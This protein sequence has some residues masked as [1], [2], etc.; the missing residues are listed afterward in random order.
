MNPEA[1][2]YIQKLLS[3]GVELK[4][5]WIDLVD[6]ENFR[7]FED[8][9]HQFLFTDIEQTTEPD[10][11]LLE[12]LEKPQCS[13]TKPIT[14]QIDEIIDVSISDK[15][16]LQNI[17]SKFPTL[18]VLINC[19]G[20][21]IAGVIHDQ[22]QNLDLDADPGVKILIKPG[23]SLL[24][25]VLMIYNDN[26]VI[27]GGNSP[28]L[29][30]QRDQAI[31][32]DSKISGF[33]NIEELFSVIPEINFGIHPNYEFQDFTAKKNS[34]NSKIILHAPFQTIEHQESKEEKEEILQ[35]IPKSKEEI[36][37]SIQKLKIEKEEIFQPI[38]KPKTESSS[39]PTIISESTS[40]MPSF[41][42]IKQSKNSKANTKEMLN[43][44]N[45]FS[46]KLSNLYPLDQT[47]KRDQ[48][49]EQ[50]SSSRYTSKRDQTPKINQDFEQ[51]SSSNAN[52][53]NHHEVL[54]LIQLFNLPV[55]ERETS[56]SVNAHVKS[57]SVNK[58]NSI[59]K[60][61]K[62]QYPFIVTLENNFNRQK[63]DI[64][65]DPLFL[66]LLFNLDYIE[67]LPP[68]DLFGTVRICEKK[69][70]EMLIPPLTI[71]DK[72]KGRFTD[73]FL[74]TK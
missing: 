59:S 10:S 52:S 14:V 71:I 66:Q 36:L 2:E 27:L 11:F 29:I 22:I 68:D 51:K 7:S 34:R 15:Y 72:G 20:F 43:T 65:I 46:T 64:S 5:S 45:Q 73:R 69:I 17:K 49:F 18:K 54:D 37:R 57:L 50:N 74:L 31:Q 58:D 4:D 24:C 70:K 21:K 39:R 13:I 61:K 32:S 47:S 6:F 41:K 26:S 33:Q 30:E 67:N 42:P 23:S 35:P 19:G 40:N 3:F 60:E 44:Q 63:I 28:Q 12:N 38:P 62:K 1:K 53:T 9:F 8:F 48:S 16:H 56:Y 55:S 25:G